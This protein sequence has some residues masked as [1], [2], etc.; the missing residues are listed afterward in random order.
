MLHFFSSA[1]VQ[2][3]Q[4]LKNLKSIYFF[5]SFNFFELHNFNHLNSISIEIKIGEKLLIH[6]DDILRLVMCVKG[7]VRLSIM[8]FFMNKHEFLDDK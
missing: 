4:I 1:W 2:L 8:F 5:Q 3:S 6:Y 7:L